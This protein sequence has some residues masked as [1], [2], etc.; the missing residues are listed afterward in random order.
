VRAWGFIA[1]LALGG[2]AQQLVDPCASVQGTCVGVQMESDFSVQLDAVDLT[3][4]GGGI[5]HMSSVSAPSGPI[6]LPAAFALIFQTPPATSTST[7]VAVTAR[8]GGLIVGSGSTVANVIPGTHTEAHVR[9]A[10]TTPPD[11]A[12]GD[13]S[14]ADLSGADLSIVPDFAQSCPL[15]DNDSCPSG[16]VRLWADPNNCGTC[17]TTCTGA[18]NVCSLAGCASS[19]AAGRVNCGGGSCIDV[20][21]DPLH[22]GSCTAMCGGA[23]PVCSGGTCVSTCPSPKTDCAGA[24]VDLQTDATHCG[25]CDTFC[26]AGKSCFGGVC[27]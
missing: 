7:T 27:N 24:C 13:L 14:G 26:P 10:V 23:N 3:V 20:M 21:T 18:T 1:A 19:C 11:A 12:S 5:N 25:V 2:C 4:S 22:C 8:L 9:I 16:C 6:Q 15:I 17:G